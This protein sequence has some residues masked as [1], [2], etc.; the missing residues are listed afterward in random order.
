VPLGIQTTE[1]DCISYG[2]SVSP[3]S[4][5]HVRAVAQRV[6]VISK[7]EVRIRGNRSELVRVLAASSGVEAAVLGTR[8]FGPKW[9]PERDKTGHFNYWKVSFPLA[10]P[11]PIDR[12][13]QPRPR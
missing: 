2:L 7:T 8:S 4:R 1:A 5:N 13:R 10:A 12:N 6:E 11:P 9:C 3:Y